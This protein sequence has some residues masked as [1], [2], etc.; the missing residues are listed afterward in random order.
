ME[1]SELSKPV[2]FRVRKRGG[3]ALI[4]V[5]SFSSF[6]LLYAAS[7]FTAAVFIFEF[8]NMR[9]E[10]MRS[11]NVAEQALAISE[12]WFSA[13]AVS[14]D[15]FT[16]ADLTESAPP[17]TDPVIRTPYD[18]MESL[19][20]INPDTSIDVV[21]IDQYYADL[22]QSAAASLKIPRSKPVS[23]FVYDADE[24]ASEYHARFVSIRVNVC[25]RSNVNSGRAYI[26]AYEVRFSEL[27]G[28]GV[29]RRS[30]K[31]Y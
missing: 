14:G 19:A 7:L 5:F 12:A 4:T 24:N 22:Y 1:N 30:A 10:V 29:V 20:A 6:A 31:K 16:S 11:D 18:L 15:I 23:Y 3:F 9:T 13:A 8:Q 17:A 28:Y 26:S 27:Y 21:I 25:Q 2:K